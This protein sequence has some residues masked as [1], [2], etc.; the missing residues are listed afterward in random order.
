MRRLLPLFLVSVLAAFRMPAAAPS[1]GETLRLGFTF[2]MFVGVNENDAR[3]SVR[4]LSETIARDS[5]ITANPTPQIFADCNEV[6]AAIHAQRVDAVGLTTLEF[7]ALQHH[8]HFDRLLF[9]TQEHDP[10]EEYVLLAAQSLA[11]SRLEELHGRRLVIVDGPRLNLAQPWLEI[12]L[13]RGGLPE[14]A[15]HFS[16]LEREP[17]P[18]RAIL[19]TY[20]KKVDVCLVTRHAL[21]VMTELNPQIGTHLRIIASSPPLIPSLFA[22]RASLAP[23]MK[24]KSLQVFTTIHETAT[25]RQALTIFQ[26]TRVEERPL[27]VLA[28]SLALVEEFHRLRP[29]QTAGAPLPPLSR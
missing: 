5:A 14:A 20:F 17:K 25:G 16:R 1:P 19:D 18:S 23:A 11:V 21:A 28:P 6:D 27:S 24:E 15:A 22:F 9:S 8:G 13:A 12:L 10:A 7:A 26:V 29:A 2:A 4:A 3:A